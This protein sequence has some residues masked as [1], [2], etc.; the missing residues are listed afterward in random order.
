MYQISSIYLE[1]AL[2]FSTY[3]NKQFVSQVITNTSRS[4]SKVL[5]VTRL[6]PYLRRSNETI[7]LIHQKIPV[8][9]NNR[10]FN[11]EIL[12]YL[13]SEFPKRPPEFYFQK[14]DQLSVEKEYLIAPEQRRDL[15]I[16]LGKYS[17]WEGKLSSLKT[18]IDK[19]GAAF[20]KKFPCFRSVNQRVSPYKGCCEYSERAVRQVILPNVPI[21]STQYKPIPQSNGVEGCPPPQQIYYSK[22]MVQTKKV[23]SL[24]QVKETLEKEILFK[25]KPHLAIYLYNLFTTK[26]AL[27]QMRT[28]LQSGNKNSQDVEIAPI[29]TKMQTMVKKYS[30]EEEKLKQDIEGAKANNSKD[31]MSL[32]NI[33]SLIDIKTPRMLDYICKENTINE[34]L[35][36]IKKACQ[37]KTF[38]F[39]DLVRQYRLLS[40]EL[41]VLQYLEKKELNQSLFGKLY[42]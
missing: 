37:K 16:N 39:A 41:F 32:I 9:Y 22:S 31:G 11:V 1:D 8:N 33:K 30:D 7:F 26:N 34:F 24:S 17:V 13:P 12:I 4:L 14:K 35:H 29:I 6:E 10:Q 40:N 19:L 18:C 21:Q 20:T 15:L 36:T 27:I 5:M 2:K 25:I 42:Y 3:K 28:R 23:M 38:N